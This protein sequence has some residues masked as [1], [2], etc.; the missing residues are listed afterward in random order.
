MILK[1]YTCLIKVLITDTEQAKVRPD[2]IQHQCTASM[3]SQQTIT[4]V[5]ATCAALLASSAVQ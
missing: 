5:A 2:R 3:H 1:E 4:V